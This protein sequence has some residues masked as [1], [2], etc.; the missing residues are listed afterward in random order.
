MITNQLLG[1]PRGYLGYSRG[2]G[3]LLSKI[4][5]MPECVVLFD[6]I[7]K[8][9]PAITDLLLQILDEGRVHDTDDNLLDFRRAFIVFTTN[10]GTTYEAGGGPIGF[11]P[12]SSD[13]AAGSGVGRV[14][15][16]DVLEDLRRRGYREEFLGRNI[17]FIVFDALTKDS[18]EIILR[19]QLDALEGTAEI[20][21]YDFSWDPAIVKHLVD[22]WQPRFGVRHLTAILKNRILEQLAIADVQG[23]LVDIEEIRLELAEDGEVGS[24]PTRSIEGTT[25]AISIA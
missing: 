24:L 4:R 20:Q 10:A 18:I 2:E 7:E 22:Q 3:G 17:E 12:R 1:V 23:E 11:A 9:N 21:G 16:D 15:K 14:T 5:D 8:A 13:N 25:M 6:E 19:R